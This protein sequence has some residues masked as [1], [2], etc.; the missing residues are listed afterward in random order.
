MMPLVPAARRS[1]PPS[2]AVSL[3]KIA[4]EMPDR[5]GRSLSQ[6]DCVELGRKLAADGVVPRISPQT[7]A[8]ILQD[9]RLK[10]WR[11]HLW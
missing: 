4:C 6:W 1:F 7:V 3:V 11:Y 2:V 9:H 8:R 5:L 10:P